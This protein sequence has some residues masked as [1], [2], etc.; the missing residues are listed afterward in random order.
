MEEMNEFLDRYQILKLNQNQVNGLNN[1]IT[2]KEIKAV[3]KCLPTKKSPRT[4][5]F[6]SEFYQTFIDDLIPILSKLSHKIESDGT[7]P[8]S[9]FKA[10]ITL[11]PKPHYP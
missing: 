6:S 2:H 11:V 5:G 7:L 3:I 8:N 4:D 10:K 1:P 9:F